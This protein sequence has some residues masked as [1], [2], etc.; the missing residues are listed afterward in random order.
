[1][2]NEFGSDESSCASVPSPPY[3]GAS[4][5]DRGRAH[6]R[7][8]RTAQ[9]Y[10][11]GCQGV[12]LQARHAACCLDYAITGDLL[13]PGRVDIFERRESQAFVEAF[14]GSGPSDDQSA[15]MISASVAE[16]DLAGTRSLT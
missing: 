13:D 12:V 4:H 11:A 15:V 10:L 1:M 5:G 9:S 16:Y 6:R 2:L 7:Q 8:P 14:R 3:E